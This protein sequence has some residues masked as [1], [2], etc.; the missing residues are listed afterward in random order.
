MMWFQNRIQNER[1]ATLEAAAATAMAE[2]APSLA[3]AV[4]PT[5]R[6]CEI[7]GYIPHLSLPLLSLYTHLPPSPT[8]ARR[9]I[10]EAMAPWY[11]VHTTPPR[12]PS[13]P[14]E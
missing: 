8:L 2:L 14:F 7:P 5:P 3:A 9:P 11:K 4:R 10:L 6:R 1:E 12:M 13:K